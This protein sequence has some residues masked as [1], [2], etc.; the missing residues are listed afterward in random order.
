[1]TIGAGSFAALRM[2]GAVATAFALGYDRSMPSDR[3]TRW[4]APVVLGVIVLLIYV[5]TLYPSVAGGDAGE[6]VSAA[7]TFGV[8]HPPGYPLFALLARAFATIPVGDV[9]WRVNLLA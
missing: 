6:L 9:A 2:T 1:M 4:T 7:W 8:P 3:D 5:L